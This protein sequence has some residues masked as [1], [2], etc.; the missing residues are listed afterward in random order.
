[1]RQYAIGAIVPAYQLEWGGTFGAN[2]ILVDYI[3]D[4][5]LGKGENRGAAVLLFCDLTSLF[6]FI[7]R[8]W[9]ISDILQSQAQNRKR[10][11]EQRQRICA[12]LYTTLKNK[13][14]GIFNLV[15]INAIALE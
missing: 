10:E 7:C 15:W 13:I 5:P 11:Q 2:E 4:I 8:Q 1:M 3:D 6:T 14:D 12:S 9:T